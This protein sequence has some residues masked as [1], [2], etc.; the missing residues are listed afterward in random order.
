MSDVVPLWIDLEGHNAADIRC[1]VTRIRSSATLRVVV[2]RQLQ[3]IVQV[4]LHRKTSYTLHLDLKTQQSISQSVSHS[5]SV[6]QAGMSAP[7]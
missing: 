7:Q 5:Q 1:C 6:R 2:D 3:M 4:R